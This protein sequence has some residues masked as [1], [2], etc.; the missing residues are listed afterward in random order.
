MFVGKFDN[1][2]GASGKRA[3]RLFDRH[4]EMQERPIPPDGADSGVFFF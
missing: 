1:M 4:L 2:Q 3:W